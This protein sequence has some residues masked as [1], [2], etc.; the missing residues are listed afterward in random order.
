MLLQL[1]VDMGIIPVYEAVLLIISGKHDDSPIGWTGI[2]ITPDFEDGED[3]TPFVHLGFREGRYIGLRGL[4]CLPLEGIF[5]PY[6]GVR[7][8]YT[9]LFNIA[10]L[11]VADLAEQPEWSDDLAIKYLPRTV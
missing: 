11:I 5:A 9:R 7:R 8:D 3:N 6:I 1:E 4:G 10:E 2:Y